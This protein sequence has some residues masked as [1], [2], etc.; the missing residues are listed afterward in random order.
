MNKKLIFA[1][2]I[3]IVL[4][5]PLINLVID[6]PIMI[7]AQLLAGKSQVFKNASK[8]MQSSC[9]NC[10]SSRTIWPWYAGLPLAGKIIQRDVKDGREEINLERELYVSDQKPSAETLKRIQHEIETD[11]MPPLEY[12]ALH[13]KAFL[14][15]KEKAVLLKWIDAERQ[16]DA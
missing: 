2:L 8:V 15:S 14:N 12:K 10:H 13:W 7:P 5:M 4:A 16:A 6:K 9:L 1:A 11:A 3:L